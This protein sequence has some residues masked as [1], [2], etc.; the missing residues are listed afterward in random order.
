MICCQGLLGDRVR[1]MMTTKAD[2]HLTKGRVTTVQNT[3]EG[4]GKPSS[5]FF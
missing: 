4:Y 3:D 5:V 1:E 2:L